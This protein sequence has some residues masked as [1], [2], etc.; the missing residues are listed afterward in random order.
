MLF[1]RDKFLTAFVKGFGSV[2]AKQKDGINFLLTK[3]ENDSAWKPFDLRLI[4]Y[5]L[6]TIKHETANTFQPIKEYRAKAGTKARKNQDRYWLSGFYGR[7]YVQITW[8]SNYHSFGIADNPDKALEPETAYKIASVGMLKGLFTGHRLGA[9]ADDL[10]GARKVINGEDKA[11]LIAKIARKIQACLSLS[12]EKEPAKSEPQ[13]D[14][15]PTETVLTP[16]PA[17]VETPSQS[18]LTDKAKSAMAA[19]KEADEGI[20]ALIGRS[21]QGLWTGISGLVA[22]L[23]NNPVKTAIA[24]T[25]LVLGFIVLHQYNKRQDSKTLEKIKAGIR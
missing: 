25:V 18:S 1:N 10:V 2:T 6:A 3:I 7:G 21:L 19:Y 13:P 17:P 22:I 23:Q 8:E 24:I 15:Q 11:E 12:L 16:A 14:V 5:F 20:K 9:Y 4:S